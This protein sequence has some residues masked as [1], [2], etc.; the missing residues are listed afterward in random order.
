[1]APAKLEK[2]KAQPGF[3][4]LGSAERKHGGARPL[5]GTG[6]DVPEPVALDIDPAWANRV[7]IA[8][9]MPTMPVAAVSDM[10]AI[11]ASDDKIS[12]ADV[13]VDRD[14][15]V[16]VD[17]FVHGDVSVDRDI[18]VH[19]FLLMDRLRVSRGNGKS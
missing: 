13:P 2:A 16:H 4:C 9:A 19:V 11:R 12:V 14:I 3:A 15:A 10:A 1:L 5:S 18:F 17:V 7:G 6:E 8:A